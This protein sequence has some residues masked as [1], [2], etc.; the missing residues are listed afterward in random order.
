MIPNVTAVKLVRCGHLKPKGGIMLYAALRGKT[1]V[2]V[3]E[4]ISCHSHVV[5]RHLIAYVVIYCCYFISLFVF[6]CVS[7]LSAS[8]PSNVLNSAISVS[9]LHRRYILKSPKESCQVLS[10]SIMENDYLVAYEW[11]MSYHR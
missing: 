8:C 2:I 11:R 4:T 3:G 6:R 7:L 1:F 10:I 5:N 9:S